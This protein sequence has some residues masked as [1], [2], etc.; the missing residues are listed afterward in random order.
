MVVV[1]HGIVGRTDLPIPEW[2]FG[3]AAAVVLVASFVALAVLWPQPRLQ[4]GGFRPL[5]AGLSRALGHR[6]VE[7][8]CGAV[9]V[10]LLLLVVYSGLSG[11]QAVTANFAPNF[12]FVVFWVGL[13]PASILLG[14]VF[15]ALNPWRALGRTVAWI[16]QTAARE[17]LPAPLAYPD[18]LGYLP[19]VAGLF[20]F[21]VLELVASN[22][23]QPRNVAI[24]TLVYSAITFV[25]MALYGVEAWI[26]RGE[27]FSVYFGLFARISPWTRREGRLGLR[28]P[29]SGLAGFEPLPGSMLLLAVMIGTVTFDGAAEAPI[30]TRAAPPLVDAFE[31]IGLSPERA[32]E[33]TFFVGLCAGVA[34]IYGIYRLGVAG[35]ASVGG[36]VGGRQLARAFVHTLVPIATAYALAHYL[37]LL[38]YQG[39]SMRFLA[40]NPL[41]R[42]GTNI[43]GTAD[44]AIDYGVI[45][46]TTVWYC[47][48][49]FVVVGHVA[50]LTL[51]HDRAL[52][53]YDRASLAVRSQYWLL[54]VMVGFTSLALWLLAQSN[55]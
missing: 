16:A 19:A 42:D 11:A 37:T 40:S 45:G 2:L 32:L 8:V 31:S 7:G 10:G 49:A 44:D 13:V 34:L 55:G 47:Q 5:P 30:W 29:L 22:G 48:A 41:G 26:G 21:T 35:A 28:K 50:A 6:V 3:W 43:F 18:R 25:A 23:D 1:A 14:D 33:A 20:A 52:V 36:G 51:A 4:D 38:A 9:G 39:Q 15:R 27:A 54:V 24:A 12:V 17:P 46:A 53:T